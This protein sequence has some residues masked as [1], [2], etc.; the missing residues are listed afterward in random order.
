MNAICLQKEVVLG[1]LGLVAR[2]I[3][4]VSLSSKFAND[5]EARYIAWPIGDVNHVL[6]R[7]ATVLV[8]QFSV[9][10]D[11]AV[12]VRALVDL[13]QG[14]SLGR[15]VDHHADLADFLVCLHR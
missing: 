5:G 13:E 3:D 1:E 10:V 2:F 12:F 4:G 8:G 14:P 7:N 15:I 6:K 9:H 11:R